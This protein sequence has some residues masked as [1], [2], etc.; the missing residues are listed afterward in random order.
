MGH[1]LSPRARLAARGA[2]VE[3]S[4]LRSR[5]YLDVWTC[6][7]DADERL[8]ALVVDVAGN[9]AR[10]LA[11]ILRALLTPLGIDASDEDPWQEVRNVGPASLRVVRENNPG[12]AFRCVTSREAYDW[13]ASLVSGA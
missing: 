8:V 12:V 13:V 11:T 5:N 4:A 3:L 1:Q 9:D 2:P 10:R 7:R 6:R